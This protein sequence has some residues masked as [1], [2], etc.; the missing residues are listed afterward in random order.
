MIVKLHIFWNVLVANLVLMGISC[1][2]ILIIL[3]V[4]LVLARF[5]FFVACFKVSKY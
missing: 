4:I 5:Q 3:A 1:E 2:A